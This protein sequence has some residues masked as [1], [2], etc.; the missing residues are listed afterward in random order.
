MQTADTRSDAQE[1]PR[2]LLKFIV[3]YRT[4]ESPPMMFMLSHMNQMKAYLLTYSMV[5]SP[6]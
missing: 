5:Q 4:Y 1:L 6:S 2:L 3:H